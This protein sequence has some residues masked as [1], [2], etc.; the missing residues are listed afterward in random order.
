M[1]FNFSLLQR[2]DD[3]APA[4]STEIQ[5][6]IVTHISKSPVKKINPFLNGAN[7]PEVIRELVELRQYILANF[8]HSIGINSNYNLKRAQISNEEIK[9]NDDI[10]IVNTYEIKSQLEKGCKEFNEKTGLNISVRY[11]DAWQQLRETE[12]A[13]ETE[14]TEETDEKN[15]E[16]NENENS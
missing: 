8:Y 1:Q 14:T 6:Q 15:S 12:T 2:A 4:G 5:C 3:G 11:S 10:L 16:E 13:E 7:I 9:T